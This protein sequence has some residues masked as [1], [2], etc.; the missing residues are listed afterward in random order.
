M[1][2]KVLPDWVKVGMKRFDRIRNKIQN[3]K[4]NNL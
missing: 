2:D 1:S 4:N 3:A